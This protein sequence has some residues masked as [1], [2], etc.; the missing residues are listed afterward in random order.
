MA[1]CGL[2]MEQGATRGGDMSFTPCS[3][4]RSTTW[5]RSCIGIC[6]ENILGDACISHESLGEQIHPLHPDP[7]LCSYL[8]LPLV[9]PP[10]LLQKNSSIHVQTAYIFNLRQGFCKVQVFGNW[11]ILMMYTTMYTIIFTIIISTMVNH[12]HIPISA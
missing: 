4:T 2:N 10:Y 11:C 1:P 9:P 6:P 8:I 12:S 3:T 5:Q 7:L